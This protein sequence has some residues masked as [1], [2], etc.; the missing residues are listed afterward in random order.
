MWNPFKRKPKHEHK[1]IPGSSSNSVPL[2]NEAILD[3]LTIMKRQN[4]QLTQKL[5]AAKAE[6]EKRV[7]NDQSI[8]NGG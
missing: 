5:L 2:D 3:E 7:A 1:N 8:S 6:L 4:R